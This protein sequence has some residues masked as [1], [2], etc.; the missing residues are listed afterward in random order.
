MMGGM[1]KNVG[2]HVWKTVKRKAKKV[3][4]SKPLIW[5]WL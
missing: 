3:N 1:D 2:H 5:S 4:S